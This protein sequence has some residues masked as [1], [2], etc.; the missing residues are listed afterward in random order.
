MDSVHKNGHME[1]T[2][3]SAMEGLESTGASEDTR[4]LV[5]LLAKHCSEEG[6]ML[7]HYQR[8]ALEAQ[9]PETRYLVLL[10]LDDERRHHRLLV[11]MANAIAW[12][13]SKESPEPAVPDMT[14]DDA[15]N[16]ALA[17]ETRHLLKAEQN[18][19]VELKRLRKRLRPFRDQTLWEL[20]VDLMITD[21]EKHIQILHAITEFTEDD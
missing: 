1:D 11:E 12:G 8:F 16:R 13:M 2:F 15:G 14:H 10:I 18:D 19:R 6:T 20:I 21:T 17:E 4:D 5:E 3:G 9:A 7:Q